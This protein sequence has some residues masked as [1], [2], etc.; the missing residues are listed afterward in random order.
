MKKITQNLRSLLLAFTAVALLASCGED[1]EVTFDNPTVDV[2]ATVD[3]ATVTSGSE[4]EVGSTISFAVTITAQG[5]V[6]G[7]TVNNTSYSRTQLGAEAGD[8]QATF[9][10]TSE[11]SELGEGTFAFQSVDDAGQ[12]ST[13]FVFAVTVVAPASPDA[14][15]QTA[16]IL[17]APDADGRETAFYSVAENLLYSHSDVTGTAA[18]VSQNIDFG[19]Y[20]GNT[21]E[22]SLV[23]P[24][25]YPTA[26][27]DISAWTVKNETAMIQVTDFTLE[28]FMALSTVADV[29]A[30][31]ESVSNETA[32]LGFTG[33]E[34]GTVI[35]FETAGEVAGILRVQSITTGF[36]GSIEVEM[37]LAEAAE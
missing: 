23:S 20:Y 24:S 12:V 32:V 26:V 8:T 35:A 2:V 30:V 13:E 25:N 27:F 17:S 9:T 11:L 10:I 21:D 36:S 29:E 1:D 31:L 15:V 7:L 28:D 4:V 34:V 22:A 19:Y 5:G 37:I 14:K 33:L 16:I 6:N 3:G 18:A